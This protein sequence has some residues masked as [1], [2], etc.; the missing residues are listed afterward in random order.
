[1]GSCWMDELSTF[2]DLAQLPASIGGDH[3]GGIEDLQGS[4]FTFDIAEG[5]LLWMPES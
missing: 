4:L 2:I 5:G 1:M 3:P